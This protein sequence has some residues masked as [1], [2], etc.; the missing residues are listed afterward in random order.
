MLLFL[1]ISTMENV[2]KP[3]KKKW[4]K[5]LLI[6][7]G[8][9]V[10]A[11]AIFIYVKFYFVFGEG[12][13]S[14]QLNFIVHKGY[15]FKTWEGRMIQVGYRSSSGGIQS[16]EFE[17]SVVD[18]EVA[19]RLELQSGKMLD[20]HYKEYLGTLPWRGMSKYIVDSIVEI[21]EPVQDGLP[22]VAVP[23]IVE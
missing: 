20:L 11:L 15:V 18:E 4:R 5:L 14:G 9:V 22:P 3:K 8:I 17:F 10:L 1:Y 19:K 13:K 16:N 21:R 12:V 2:E 7:T 6:T 23:S